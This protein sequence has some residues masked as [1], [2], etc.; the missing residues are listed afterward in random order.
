MPPA[1]Q[2]RRSL[3]K[4]NNM[5]ITIPR[6]FALSVFLISGIAGSEVYDQ[7]GLMPVPS[8]SVGSRADSSTRGGMH[9]GMRAGPSST[10]GSTSRDGMGMVGSATA[11]VSATMSGSA[12]AG[13]S[14]TTIMHF[15]GDR[16]RNSDRNDNGDQNAERLNGIPQDG[17]GT[18]LGARNGTGSSTRGG[19]SVKSSTGPSVR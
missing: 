7:S 3:F 1:S 8:A 11:A 17:D 14:A 18:G 4:E 19:S 10:T 16:D 6:M 15:G 12:T 2:G 9:D 13:G 5:T